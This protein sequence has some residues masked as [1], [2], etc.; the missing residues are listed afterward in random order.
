MQ[1]RKV[2]DVVG[3]AMLRLDKPVKMS[4]TIQCLD[5]L[6]DNI[7]MSGFSN[8]YSFLSR[9]LRFGSRWRSSII[10]GNRQ[11]HQRTEVGWDT[12]G[13][14]RH[15]G[16]SLA[17]ECPC[18]TRLAKRTLSSDRSL[19]INWWSSPELLAGCDIVCINHNVCI[20]HIYCMIE[21]YLNLVWFF[22]RSF[23]KSNT[24]PHNLIN[25][26]RS[27]RGSWESPSDEAGNCKES[28]FLRHQ[29][30]KRCF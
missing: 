14:H 6:V 29:R 21:G 18:L 7:I 1:I 28:W 13:P 3:L 24:V 10:S 16:L 15:S 30:T 22:L 4:L 12:R 23:E 5:F 11:H 8:G 27:G 17:L 19:W 9:Y 2:L 20:N 25:L 26:H